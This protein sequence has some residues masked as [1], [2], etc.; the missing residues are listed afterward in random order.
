MHPTKDFFISYGR[1]ESLGF[2]ARLH[3]ALLLAG[4]TGW[5]DK[6]NIPDGEAYDKRISNGIESAD[7]FVFVMAPRCLTSPYC[8]IELEY[9]RVLGKR[10]IPVNQ[11]VIFQTEDKVLSGGDQAVLRGFYKANNIPDPN[12]TSTQQ[13][14]DR[15]L[16]LI[17][18]TDWLD[19][20]QTLSD[21]AC[22]ELREWAATYENSWHNHEN[23]EYLQKNDLPTFGQVTDT[24][25]SIVE[26]IILVAEK[27]KPYT[28]RHTLLTLD[29]LAWANNQ[30]SNNHLLVGK[31]RQ[32]AEEW[33]LTEFTPPKQPPCTPSDLLC[34]FIGE[35]RKNAE[36]RMTDV[37]ICYAQEDRVVRD[38]VIN[39]L[40]R[41]AVTTWIHDKDIQK[42]TTYERAI[43]SGIEGADNFFFFVSPRSVKSDYCLK[44]L[45]HA[46]KYN[47][48]PVPLLIEQTPEADIPEAL[49]G[50]Q[51]IDFTDNTDQADFLADIDDIL[52][53]LNH[54]KSYYEEHK[55]LLVR[56]LEWERS[57]RKSSFLLRGFNL[58]NA[59]AWLRIHGKR[60][61]TP[62]LALHQAFIRASDSA[63][64]QLN[65]DVFISYSRKDGDFARQLNRKLQESGKN[66]WFDQ[67]SISTGVDFEK[68]IFKGI[69]GA[70]NIVF[71]IS[72]DAVQSEYCEREVEYAESLGKRFITLLVRD[73]D[74]SDIPNVLRVI[75][76]IDFSGTEFDRPFAELVKEIDLDREHVHQHTLFQQR[77]LEW[78]EHHRADDFL[79]NN[80]TTLKASIWSKDALVFSKKPAPTELQQVFI[81]ASV[82]ALDSLK[83]KERKRQRT[84]IGVVSL[85]AILSLGFGIFGFVKMNEANRNLKA[86]K[87]YSKRADDARIT[88]NEK[89]REA[90]RAL[91]ALQTE[92][93]NKLIRRAENLINSNGYFYARANL[94]EADSLTQ[95]TTG[96][97]TM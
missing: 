24:T 97:S 12:I 60:T 65:T 86:A 33:L 46:L 82:D 91:N 96:V 35:A 81:Q 2:V 55:I 89:R 41:Y 27:Q 48:R 11:M 50:L 79:L 70:D 43:E 30:K 54:E 17:G 90:E 52:N 75:N 15:S 10:I 62:P 76:W 4:Y 38:Q 19:G 18:T 49:R 29:A 37:F 25:E 39:A 77:A 8:L 68:E 83:Q 95:D 80:T 1:R 6:V 69:E 59:N 61:E 28:Q 16:S 74:P 53:V 20:K 58:E 40:A 93:A 92:K 78:E 56:A 5:F 14:L 47:K 31:E 64:G 42:G 57:E 22:E 67:E 13:V 7:N 72:P 3:R 26:R 73:T 84:I 71:L 63:K 94:I 23:V 85:A 21:K 51:Y 36:N 88:A 44:E 45:N 9:A 34:E 87:L 66:T 32:T